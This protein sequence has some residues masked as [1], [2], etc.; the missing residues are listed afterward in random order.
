MKKLEFDWGYIKFSD[1]WLVL[2]EMKNAKYVGVV[3]CRS[4][5]HT[6]VPRFIFASKNPI[7][8]LTNDEQDKIML[9]CAYCSERFAEA[10]RNDPTS[11]GIFDITILEHDSQLAD[12][13]IVRLSKNIINKF[14]EEIVKK[15]NEKGE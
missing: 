4:T 2:R 3:S 11:I 5:Y 10:Y 1:E 7:N 6:D 14:Q 13:K 15:I 8:K 9:E 12:F